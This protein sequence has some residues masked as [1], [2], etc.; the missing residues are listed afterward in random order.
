MFMFILLNKHNVKI[1]IENI[2]FHTQF[3]FQ[4]VIT[5]K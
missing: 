2:N 1:E 5:Q 4:I 3:L